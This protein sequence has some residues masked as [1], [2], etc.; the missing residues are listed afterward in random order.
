MPD[1]AA[2]IQSGAGNPWLL[3]PAIGLVVTLSG[4]KAVS[5]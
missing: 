5:L 2:I 4:L 3:L 1:I